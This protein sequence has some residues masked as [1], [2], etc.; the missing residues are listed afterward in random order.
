MTELLDDLPEQERLEWEKSTTRV[1]D[2]GIESGDSNH[3]AVFT[4]T[5]DVVEA[6]ARI[7]AGIAV[8][9]Y[10]HYSNTEQPSRFAHVKID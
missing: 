1:V 9:F 7:G 6:A 3:Q 2:I 10:P 4:I 5:Q 8:T